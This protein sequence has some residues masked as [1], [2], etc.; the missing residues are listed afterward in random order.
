MRRIIA[1]C[2][3]AC[4]ALLAVTVSS[5]EPFRIISPSGDYDNPGGGVSDKAGAWH[6]HKFFFE[7]EHNFMMA[8]LDQ[9]YWLI[10]VVFT[11][12]YGPQQRWGIYAK[13]IDDNGK[14]WFAKRDV[15]PKDVKFSY[16]NISWKSKGTGISGT[17]PEFKFTIEE[18][19]FQANLTSTTLFPGWDTGIYYYEKGKKPFWEVPIYMPWG[20]IKGTL[21]LDGK[22]MEVTGRSYGD[23]V[24]GS[25][26][27]DHVDPI[28]YSIRGLS[29]M[30]GSAE[31]SIHVSFNKVH[32]AHGNAGCPSLILM[33]SK[34]FLKAT[35]NV[36]IRGAD[37]HTD[38]DTG[39]SF[40]RS[41]IVEADD[42][43]FKLRGVFKADRVIEIMD[44]ISQLPPYLRAIA[45]K[46]FNLPVFSKWDGVFEGIYTLKGKQRRF[47]IRSM[48]EANFIGG[49]EAIE[50]K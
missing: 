1:I 18:E 10:Y 27:F 35:Q 39:Y 37:F 26:R 2:I 40:P 14:T 17:Y 48:G 28:F 34:G 16:E 25:H 23:H 33:D 20:R 44:V 29:P 50:R 38:P 31:V 3:I 24:H 7:N 9:G 46:F 15:A 42:E 41:F 5:D 30:P 47:R 12:K 43:G 49:P 11:F 8:R 21:T 19:G 22:Q 4:L 45:V 36:K 32:P 13:V 6:K